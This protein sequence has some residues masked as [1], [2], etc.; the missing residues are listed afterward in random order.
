MPNVSADT[1]KPPPE[2]DH[3]EGANTRLQL[4]RRRYQLAALKQAYETAARS[5]RPVE[6][7]Q[8][9]RRIDEASRYIKREVSISNRKRNEMGLKRWT[10]VGM[11][12]RRTENSQSGAEAL[13]ALQAMKKDLLK[14]VQL[15]VEIEHVLAA[16]RKKALKKVE[17][18]KKK[19]RKAPESAQYKL[20][21]YRK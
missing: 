7:I 12:G 10:F 4:T 9:I 15:V 16:A 20:K 5:S 13:F 17:G 1:P 19:S 18:G 8:V 14:H 21:R 6:I 11:V 3:D 2:P